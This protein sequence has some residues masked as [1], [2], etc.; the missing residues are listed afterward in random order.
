MTI[1]HFKK[2][3]LLL[4][5]PLVIAGCSSV[6]QKK[7]YTLTTDTNNI[8]AGNKAL[9]SLMISQVK[10]LGRLSTDMIYSRSPNE[11]ESYTQSDWVTPPTQLIQGA[12]TQDLETRGLFQYV[13]MAPNSVPATNR[14]DITIQEMNQ[15]FTNDKQNHIVLRLQVHLISNAN[16]KIIRTFTYNVSEPGNA[17]NAEAGVA[18]YNRALNQIAARLATDISQ[19]LYQ[20]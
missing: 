9:P 15:I 14:L 13:I 12:L 10:S 3:M 4:A 2:M 19:T 1:K 6:P 16:N 18:A 8:I 17:Y 11:I 20:R 7:S 5:I